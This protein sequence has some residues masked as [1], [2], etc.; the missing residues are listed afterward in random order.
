MAGPGQLRGTSG[1]TVRGVVERVGSEPHATL[2]LMRASG[3]LVAPRGIDEALL[4]G[5]TGIEVMATG[6]FTEECAPEAG[7]RGARVFAM[8][9]FVVR[10]VGGVS[11]VDGILTEEN[12]QWVIVTADG[13]RLPVSRV[14][15][16]LEAMAGARVYF[17]GPLT[18]LPVAYG[19]IR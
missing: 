8:T 6:A 5:L 13:T 12:G 3:D 9:R 19:V 7:P 10:A 4:R 1:D 2:V 15:A 11:A 17:A 16:L 14:P 18:A